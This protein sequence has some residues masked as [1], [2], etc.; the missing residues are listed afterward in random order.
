MLDLLQLQVGLHAHTRDEAALH[1][2]AA[3]RYDREGDARVVQALALLLHLHLHLVQLPLLQD[4]L[5]RVELQRGED[6]PPRR[7][8]QVHV[9]L[10]GAL[11]N[12]DREVRL[13]DALFA[14]VR[15][16]CLL[17]CGDPY[18][19]RR[20]G[21]RGH[22]GPVHQHHH[23]EVVVLVGS[24][25]PH[26]LFDAATIAH[27]HLHAAVDAAEGADGHGSRNEPEAE[28]L[29]RDTEAQASEDEAN[30]DGDYT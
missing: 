13:E 16:H 26:P 7:V 19:A 20:L 18:N 6:L 2:A 25:G 11:L 24:S 27:P 28:S 23:L 5:Q 4:V 3:R 22:G 1:L 21:R 29:A 30:H 9:H 14:G 10:L 8:H 15:L 12:E 17:T